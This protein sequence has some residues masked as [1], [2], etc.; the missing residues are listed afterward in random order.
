MLKWP[1]DVAIAPFFVPYTLIWLASFLEVTHGALLVFFKGGEKKG[2]PLALF[3]W[4][5]KWS[6]GVSQARSFH[7]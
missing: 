6:S 3:R 1:K 7:V 2:I 4:P 5:L